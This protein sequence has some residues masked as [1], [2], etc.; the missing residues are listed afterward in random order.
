MYIMNHE[1]KIESKIESK[2]LTTSPVDSDEENDDISI[3]IKL[4]EPKEVKKVY[5]FFL[6]CKH[7][8]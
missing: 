1:S 7:N 4:V 5:N 3:S 2:K 8:S 6:F